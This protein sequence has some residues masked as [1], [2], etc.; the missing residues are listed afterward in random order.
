MATFPTYACVQL[1]GY[2]EKSDFLVLRSEMDSGVAKQRPR[3][4]LPIVTRDVKVKVANK[5]EKTLFD[6]WVKNDIDGGTGWFDYID[7]LDNVT[8][9]AR[10]INGEVN[11][12]SPG[13]VWFAQMKLETVG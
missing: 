5:T 10:I 13:V 11:W 2:Q 9:Q 1:E 4:S 3:R 8:K 7:P 6:T 12:S